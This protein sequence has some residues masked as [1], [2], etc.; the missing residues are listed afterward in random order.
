MCSITFFG[1]YG[2]VPIG[3][4]QKIESLVTFGISL[5]AY[6]HMTQCFGRDWASEIVLILMLTMM[7]ISKSCSAELMPLSICANYSIFMTF[8]GPNDNL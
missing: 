4:R 7:R 5:R 1:F 8:Q 6:L 3:S 2:I